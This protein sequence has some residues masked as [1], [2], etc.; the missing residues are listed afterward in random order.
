M[1]QFDVYQVLHNADNIEGRGPMVHVAYFKNY[2]DAARAAA[3]KGVMGVGDDDVKT[4][5]LTIFETFAEY[6]DG[7]SADL[8][9]RALGKLSHEE[10]VALGL[11]T[12]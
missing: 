5:K 2:E 8:R 7:V 10:K 6:N 12:K 4:V 3:G 1:K 11:I 9:K